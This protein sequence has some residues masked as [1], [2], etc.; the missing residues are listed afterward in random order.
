MAL[1]KEVSLSLLNAFLGY[2]RNAEVNRSIIEPNPSLSARKDLLYQSY[3][4]QIQNLNETA[5]SKIYF[6]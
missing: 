6:C 5:F 2:S 4:R 3:T 1:S